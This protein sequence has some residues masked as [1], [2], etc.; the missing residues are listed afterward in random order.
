M[1]RPKLYPDQRVA[2]AIRLP[3]DLHQ[4]LRREAAE[5]DVSVNLL[6]TRAVTEFVG[7]LHGT[8]ADPAEQAR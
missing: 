7:R 5:R 4:A 1:G 6:V 3:P 2:T 8:E